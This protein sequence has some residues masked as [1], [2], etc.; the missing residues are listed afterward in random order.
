M[1]RAFL[2]GILA[3]LLVCSATHAEVKALWLFDEGS[4]NTVT[5]SSGNGCDGKIEGAKYVSGKYRTGLAFDGKSY[6]QFSPV[7]PADKLTS[8]WARVKVIY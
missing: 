6:I 8:T 7:E 4:G 5:D 3:L 1:Q 2:A